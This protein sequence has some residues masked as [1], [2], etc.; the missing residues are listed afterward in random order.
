[1]AEPSRHRDGAGLER[2]IRAAGRPWTVGDIAMVADGQW[3]VG[4]KADDRRNGDTLAEQ[5]VA[6]GRRVELTVEELARAVTSRP[7]KTN[8]DE[9]GN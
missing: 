7:R 8:R 3:A 2:K 5:R 6:D 1:M 9:A 4:A